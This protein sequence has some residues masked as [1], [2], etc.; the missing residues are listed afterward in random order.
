MMMMIDKNQMVCTVDDLPYER[1]NRVVDA[2]VEFFTRQ[3]HQKEIDDDLSCWQV[4][5]DSYQI[6]FSLIYKEL[7]NSVHFDLILEVQNC[8]QQ[9]SNLSK[10]IKELQENIKLDSISTSFGKDV[11]KNVAEDIKRRTTDLI[12]EFES[13]TAAQLQCH[14]LE[15]KEFCSSFHHL[16]K[17]TGGNTQD[18]AAKA[19]LQLKATPSAQLL[20]V[21]GLKVATPVQDELSFRAPS[22]AP[23]PSKQAQELTDMGFELKLAQAALEMSKNST[24]GAIILLLENIKKVQEHAASTSVKAKLDGVLRKSQSSLS[25]S[26]NYSGGSSTGQMT[27]TLSRKMSSTS[28]SSGNSPFTNSKSHKPF[29]AKFESFLGKAIDVFRPDNIIEP[30]SA[31]ANIEQEEHNQKSETFSVHF[32]SQV[33]TMYTLRLETSLSESPFESSYNNTMSP[34]VQQ[35]EALSSLYSENLSGI[36]MLFEK[37]D[38]ESYEYLD[39]DIVTAC[40]K[41]PDLHFPSLSSQLTS[42]KANLK[43]NKQSISIGDF[44]VTKHSNLPYH[45]VFHLCIDSQSSDSS[46]LT[47]QHKLVNGYKL[48]LRYAHKFNINNLLIPIGFTGPT[49][50]TPTSINDHEVCLKATR[51]TLMELSRSVIEQPKAIKRVVFRLREKELYTAVKKSLMNVFN[52]S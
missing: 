12:K 37:S 44:I 4:T 38:Y 19:L 36:I 39:Y 16:F 17:T 22:S 29:K 51:S 2:A 32:G 13:N 5:N 9:E 41:I 24:E 47:T 49:T 23:I 10:E 28:I 50:P 42:A 7:V 33:K 52:T 3:V 34:Q 20:S 21:V 6:P 11:H 43:I 46:K 14:Q 27:P 45:V 18:L 40:Y 48:I 30:Q 1:G 31:F 35:A 8:Y 26:R 25:I 15:F